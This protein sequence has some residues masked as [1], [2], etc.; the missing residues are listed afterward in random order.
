MDLTTTG[1]TTDEALSEL[2]TVVEN[3]L[4]RGRS[5]NVQFF[6][7]DERPGCIRVAPDNYRP[8]I[9]HAAQKPQAHAVFIVARYNRDTLEDRYT[10]V[11]GLL[12]FLRE[13][14]DRVF[15]MSDE[16]TTAGGVM[17]ESFFSF[18]HPRLNLDPDYVLVGRSLLMPS[19][20]TRLVHSSSDWLSEMTMAKQIENGGHVTVDMHAAASCAVTINGLNMQL[21]TRAHRVDNIKERKMFKRGSDKG[22]DFLWECDFVADLLKSKLSRL[23]WHEAMRDTHKLPHTNRIQVPLDFPFSGGHALKSHDV[24]SSSSESDD[25]SNDSRRQIDAQRGLDEEEEERD[26]EESAKILADR[27]KNERVALGSDDVSGGQKWSVHDGSE[28]SDGLDNLSMSPPS[29]DDDVE[30][31]DSWSGELAAARRSRMR[32][33][34]SRISDTVLDRRRQEY[35]D[36]WKRT[37]PPDDGGDE[38]DSH[39]FR[40]SSRP[41]WHDDDD[42]QLGARGLSQFSIGPSPERRSVSPDGEFGASEDSEQAKAG[43]RFTVRYFMDELDSRA[44]KD[45][46]AHSTRTKTIERERRALRLSQEGVADTPPKKNPRSRGASQYDTDV[47]IAESDDEDLQEP[48][49]REGSPTKA[50]KQV[51][52]QQSARSGE[53]RG[54]AAQRPRVTHIPAHD[55]T[56]MEPSSDE[57]VRDDEEIP[58]SIEHAGFSLTQK[59]TAIHGGRPRVTLTRDSDDEEVP[60]SLKHDK[61]SLTQ[62][63]TATTIRGELRRSASPFSYV[64]SELYNPNLTTSQHRGVSQ[65]QGSPEQGISRGS[66]SPANVFGGNR[67][68]PSSVPGSPVYMGDVD[69]GEG[70]DGS[71]VAGGVAGEDVGENVDEDVDVDVDEDVGEDIDEDEG[72]DEYEYEGEDVKLAQCQTCGRENSL[73]V[74]LGSGSAA[75]PV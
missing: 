45:R 41:I 29:V 55:P 49:P 71:G 20:F 14:N 24:S 23:P 9:M 60:D 16:D 58:G 70:G 42:E 18:L 51:R 39:I 6:S 40:Q 67:G 12:D 52:S 5:R 47:E 19:V 1:F 44:D 56:N 3:T 22:R 35:E 30:S 8:I 31:E 69:Y 7:F 54:Y 33:D 75:D 48:V 66:K 61:G 73:I 15:F 68:S 34:K 72:E 59:P 21:G 38:H 17:N 25:E 64:N 63:T 46:A 62:K 50:Q 32:D 57:E 53:S 26:R 27:K 43:Q 28:S 74:C 37:M 10:A 13:K 2:R 65:Q 36:D 4:I 11:H